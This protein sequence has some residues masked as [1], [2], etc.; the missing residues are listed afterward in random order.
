MA[1]TKQMVARKKL[2]ARQKTQKEEQLKQEKEMRELELQVR[3]EMEEQHEQELLDAQL[4]AGRDFANIVSR[5]NA[6][7]DQQGAVGG[8]STVHP[9]QNVYEWFDEQME[10]GKKP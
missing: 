6:M 2:L 10:V 5:I 4:T 8:A 7:K 1:F 9:K 3:S